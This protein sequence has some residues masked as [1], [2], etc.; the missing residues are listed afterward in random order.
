MTIQ[1]TSR[2]AEIK[3]EISQLKKFAAEAERDMKLATG[4]GYDE[5]A[6]ESHESLMAY[7]E[8]IRDLKIELKKLHS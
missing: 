7:R 4:A 8:E 6:C 1:N 5:E 2:A 3:A